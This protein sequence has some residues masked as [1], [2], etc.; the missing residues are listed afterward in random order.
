[1]Q[2]F[3]GKLKRN[4]NL[5]QTTIVLKEKKLCTIGGIELA[6]ILG[7]PLGAFYLISKNFDALENN[8]QVKKNLFYG[9]IFTILIIGSVFLFSDNILNKIPP[10]MF[11]IIYVSIIGVYARRIQGNDIKEGL[12][13]GIKK[14]SILKIIGISILSLVFS[15]AFFFILIL[16]KY[17]N[18]VDFKPTNIVGFV[19]AEIGYMYQSGVIVQQNDAEAA[20]WLRRA[21]ERNIS[22]AQN[23]LG[24]L[25]HDGKG[26]QQNDVE[27]AR[28]Y[29]KSAEQGNPTGQNN[30]GYAYHIG[31]GVTQSDVEAIKWIRKAAD[32]GNAQAQLNLAQAYH[33]GT[34]VPQDNIQAMIWLK[35]SAAQGFPEAREL[36]R[37]LTQ[38][39]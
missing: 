8:A 22:D 31:Q 1:M 27:A 7:G 25:Y 36:L 3:I 24:A 9:F 10:F 32:Q 35:K 4:M 39:N 12:L 13:A 11:P 28:W 23:D 19:D 15:A 18:I 37:N 17:T 6:A 26:V 2:I 21:A 14:Y 34:G 33:S 29:L 38:N 30:I 5:N 16:F 20:K